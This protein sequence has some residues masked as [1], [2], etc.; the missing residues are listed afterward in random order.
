MCNNLLDIFGRSLHQP[1]Q[2]NLPD[3]LKVLFEF[4]FNDN[5]QQKSE[6]S[7]LSYFRMK[8]KG[9]MAMKFPEDINN[10]P[11]NSNIKYDICE[12]H[13]HKELKEKIHEPF[14][15]LS[16]KA[17]YKFYDDGIEFEN[18]GS[19]GY[20]KLFGL[21]HIDYLDSGDLQD[22][23]AKALFQRELEEIKEKKYTDET[24]INSSVMKELLYSNYLLNEFIV[25]ENNLRKER[26]L[27]TH[28]EDDQHLITLHKL[29]E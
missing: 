13:K 26:I 17:P 11:G 20:E 12:S 3:T 2:F 28:K 5:D 10:I 4:H 16:S 15:V 25:P 23:K 22:M 29:Q 19:D 7:F 8:L 14:E 1:N 6:I 27:K 21:K 9:Q 18:L 24:E